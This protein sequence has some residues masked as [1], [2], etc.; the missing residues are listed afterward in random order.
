MVVL[1]E[2]GAWVPGAVPP[3]EHLGK[4]VTEVL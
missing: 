1:E 4:P 3:E 2:V